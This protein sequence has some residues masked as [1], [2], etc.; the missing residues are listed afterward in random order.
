MLWHDYHALLSAYNA[1][2]QERIRAAFEFSSHIHEGQR[3]LSGEPFVTHPIAVSRKII[4]LELDAD[5]VIAALLHDCTEDGLATLKEVRQRFGD[6]VAFLVNGVSKVERIRYQGIERATESVRKM[7]LAMAQDIRVVL[8]KLVDRAHNLETLGAMP[9]AKRKRIALESLELYAPLADRLGMGDLK[10]QIEDLAFRHTHPEEC[11]W[12][13][14]ETDKLI[15]QREQY[16]ARLTPILKKRLARAGI[17][18][19]DI[20]AR[21]KHYYSVWKKLMR[22]D[23]DWGRVFDLVALRIIVPDVETCYHTL[24]ALHQHWRPLPG[25]IKDYIALPKPNG[26]QSLHTTVFGERGVVTEF[27]I[28]TPQ[29]H[30][31]AEKGIAAHWAWEM[32]GKPRTTRPVRTKKFAWVEQMRRWQEEFDKNRG[33]RSDFLESLKIDF[34]K[35]RIFVLSPKGDVVDLPEHATPIDFA[36]HIHTDIGNHATG[37]KVNGKLVSF[38]HQLQSGD[39]VEIRTQKNRRPKREWLDFVQTNLAKKQIRAAV[40]LR[41]ATYQSPK[42]IALELSVKNRIGLLKDIASLLSSH[43]INIQDIASHATKKNYPVITVAF[44]PKH[45]DQLEKVVTKLKT[46]RGIEEITVKARV[47]P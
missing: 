23:M 37:A 20:H 18:P 40:R 44:T 21:I 5:T 2:E 31:D 32:A 6:D 29:M 42:Q 30:R 34:F 27:Q 28:R 17:R 46:I 41:N 24:G 26:Y 3:R 10:A 4:E 36:Y 16:L 11:G 45:I 22:Y 15:Q 7:F 13:V 14:S 47:T 43:R 1:E 9:E 38:S 25:R 19:L 35:D 33:E 8:I 12:I 39:V